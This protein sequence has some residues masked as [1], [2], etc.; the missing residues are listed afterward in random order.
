MN[1]LDPRRHRF[2]MFRKFDWASGLGFWVKVH[3]NCLLNVEPGYGNSSLVRIEIS[4][5][6]NELSDGD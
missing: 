6:S 4:F 2:Y 1:H 3:G 5:A